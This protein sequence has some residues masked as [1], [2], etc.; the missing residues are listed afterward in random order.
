MNDLLWWINSETQQI[1]RTLYVHNVYK[2]FVET[3]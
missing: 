1:T 2:M 3:I